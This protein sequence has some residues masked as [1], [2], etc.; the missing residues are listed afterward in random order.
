MLVKISSVRLALMLLPFLLPGTSM[1]FI[2]AVSA[3][4]E[5]LKPDLILTN[6]R[7]VTMD[8]R[9]SVV[10]AVAVKGERI[11]K[12]G[13]NSEIKPMAGKNTRILDL[14][15]RVMLP[16]LVDAHSHTDGV[17]PECLDLTQARSIAE[18]K[19]AV[20]KKIATTPVG[21]W[22]VGAGPFMFW[23]GWDERRLQEKRLV[24]R[25]DLD[26]ISPNHPVLLMKD[27]GHA[28]VLNSFALKL[29]NITKDTPDPRKEIVKDPATGEP[30]GVLLE[31]SMGLGT[32]LLPPLS[33]AERMAAARNASDQLLRSGIT[34]VAAMSVSPEDIGTFQAL[35]SRPTQSLVSTVLC[36]YV[37][38]TRPVD[39]VLR[40]VR[41]SGV[42]TG[43]GNEHLKLGALK[44]FVDGGITGRAAWFK[45]AYKNRPD[46]YGIPQVEK[47]TL[48]ATVRLADKLGWQIHLHVCGDAA[49][50]LA[51]DAL[52]AA[53]K[54][55]Q[56]EGRRHI[57]THLYILSPEMIARM[58]R[59]GIVAVL[60]PN[61]VYALGEHMREALNEDQL[62]NIVPVRSL[63][64]GQVPVA[65]GID[66]LP[67]NPMYA[68]YA[69]VVRRTDAG[70]VLAASEAVTVKEALRAYTKTSAY[71]LFEEQR[72]GSIEVGKFA[73]LIVL[74]RDIFKVPNDEI[75]D[76]KVLLT[77]K[78]GQ[79]ALNQLSQAKVRN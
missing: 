16:G 39:E 63:L 23:Q 10:E 8:Q 42:I 3:T 67:Q 53:Q 15:G 5:E 78:E 61:F 31:A 59:L 71:A 69:A 46:F 2:G 70:N 40:F 29:A 79:I 47:E 74:D 20:V 55:N 45:K 36:P 48:F 77:I 64:D 33:L 51:L 35:Y 32:S 24:T 22:I 11:I 6:G 44:I 21:T 28:L 54:E 68:I 75:K 65:L 41:G 18:I 12:V 17:S 60:Q 52:E 13:S 62:T 7:V 9:D 58:R 72:R 25:W 27:A 26:P 38:A 43:F 57:L 34:T 1:C 66:G 56:T 30:T 4:Q 14:G 76:V 49:A 19:D 50:E 73:D 37:P